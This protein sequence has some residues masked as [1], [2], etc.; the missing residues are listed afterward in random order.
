MV[1]HF[2]VP[3]EPLLGS[4]KEITVE[5]EE[6]LWQLSSLVAH[7]LP[8]ADLAWLSWQAAPSLACHRLT[9]PACQLGPSPA[10]LRQRTDIK[11][12]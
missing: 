12:L 10:S 7:R 3:L 9:T 6:R 4:L 11:Q 8:H 1:C 2:L 5:K